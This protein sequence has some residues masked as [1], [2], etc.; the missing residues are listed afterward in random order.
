MANTENA[1][2]SQHNHDT[3]YAIVRDVKNG[4]VSINDAVAKI[5]GL[6]D[7]TELTVN[8]F[9]TAENVKTNDDKPDENAPKAEPAFIDP[10][11]GADADINDIVGVDETDDT[12][13]LRVVPDDQ[14]VS[15]NTELEDG[16]LVAKE[17]EDEDTEVEDKRPINRRKQ[18]KLAAQEKAEAESGGTSEGNSR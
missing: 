4:A 9:D 13:T 2:T 12:T 15:K 6:Q 8:S 18:K 14:L 1:Q 16:V 10:G 7:G 3:L 11:E 17:P 5:K